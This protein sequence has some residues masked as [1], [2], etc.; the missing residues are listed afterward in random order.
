MNPMGSIGKKKKKKKK[1]VN[2]NQDGEQNWDFAQND[3]EII[4]VDS[5]AVP[6][7]AADNTVEENTVENS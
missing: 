1:K 4:K 6:E 2:N 3:Q 5:M 7:Y